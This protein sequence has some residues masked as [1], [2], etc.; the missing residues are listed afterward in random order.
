MYLF[1][2]RGVELPQEKNG[3][4]QG[5]VQKLP[6]CP[7]WEVPLYTLGRTQLELT[8]GVGQLLI[9]RTITINTY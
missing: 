5:A 8:V 4:L 6:L 7:Q 3:S 2:G 9:N 1:T